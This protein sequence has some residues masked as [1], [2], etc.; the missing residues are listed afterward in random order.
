MGYELPTDLDNR[1]RS[2]LASG[3]F[4]SA[5]EVVRM[6]LDTLD[7]VEASARDLQ[8]IVNQARDEECGIPLDQAFAIAT[9]PDSR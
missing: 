6:A 1:V 9:F 3:R 2:W 5:D 4:E 8:D 7:S